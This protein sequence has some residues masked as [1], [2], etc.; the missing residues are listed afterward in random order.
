MACRCV[1]QFKSS[2]C[3]RRM[4]VDSPVRSENRGSA[5]MYGR[6][7]EV[8]GKCMF[9][10]SDSVFSGLSLDCWKRPSGARNTLLEENTKGTCVLHR[11]EAVS[12]RIGVIDIKI[13]W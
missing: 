13:R 12:M 1:S 4:E 10:Y 3:S 6:K 7:M 2:L 9:S 11:K 8:E 5:G